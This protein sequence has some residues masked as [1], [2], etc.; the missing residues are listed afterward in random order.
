MDHSLANRTPCY[1]GER[2]EFYPKLA[3][4]KS[5]IPT[6]FFQNSLFYKT[7]NGHFRNVHFSFF[8]ILNIGS[9]SEKNKNKVWSFWTNNF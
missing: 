4:H 2:A 9:K 5:K 1:R 7:K 8:E 3:H 6:F